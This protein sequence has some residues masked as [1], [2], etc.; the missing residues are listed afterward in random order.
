M[1]I[2]PDWCEVTQPGVGTNRYAYTGNDPVNLR[3]PGG[4]ASAGSSVAEKDIDA[5]YE[6]TDR[7]TNDS[8]EFA[9][10]I[11]D[12]AKSRSLPLNVNSEESKRTRL[13]ATQARI[14]KAFP[15]V[16]FDQEKISSI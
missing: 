16:A 4:N 3:D 7:V 13:E 12:L 14:E 9:K 2:E 10:D 5:F 6:R 15:G 8:R 1:F 11:R